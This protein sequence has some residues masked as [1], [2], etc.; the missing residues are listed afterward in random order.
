MIGTRQVPIFTAR[1]C[2]HQHR[3]Q[4]RRPQTFDIQARHRTHQRTIVPRRS[5]VLPLQLLKGEVISRGSRATLTQSKNIQRP[6]ASVSQ[7]QRFQDRE[8]VCR[9]EISALYIMFKLCDCF[10]VGIFI[11]QTWPLTKR[12]SLHSLSSTLSSLSRVTK[13]RTRE[14]SDLKGH[15]RS[16]AGRT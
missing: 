16:L 9:S 13:S 4:A 14:S 10:H 6:S 7:I 11:S 1:E 5:L 15:W 3:V 2:L 8:T 12:C